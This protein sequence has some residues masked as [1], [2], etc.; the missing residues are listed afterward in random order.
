MA[1]HQQFL[2]IPLEKR[3]RTSPVSS[4]QV[5]PFPGSSLVQGYLDRTE[6]QGQKDQNNIIA[7]IRSAITEN[8]ILN[9]QSRFLRYKIIIMKDLSSRSSIFT[10][11]LGNGSEV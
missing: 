5:Q 8:Y 11:I 3:C 10:T 7:H 4:L 1:A 9:S 2:H 6:G